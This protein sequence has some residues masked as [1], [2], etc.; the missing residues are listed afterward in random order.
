MLSQDDR[1]RLEMIASQ[2]Q[3]EDPDLARALREG[4]PRS[5]FA[6]RQW[7]L[8]VGAVFAGMVFMLGVLTAAVTVMVLGAAGFGY[9]L[10]ML[11][12]RLCRSRGP[13]VRQSRGRR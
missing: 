10:T 2:L 13:R 3:I 9:A 7:P 4:R 8:V 6:R 12:F 1:R 5:W 11:W